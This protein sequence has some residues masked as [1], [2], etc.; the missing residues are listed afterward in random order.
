MNGGKTDLYNLVIEDD[1]GVMGMITGVDYGGK[2]WRDDGDWK[3][4]W[5]E[6]G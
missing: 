4:D 5:W 2:K 1:H 6:L 3:R